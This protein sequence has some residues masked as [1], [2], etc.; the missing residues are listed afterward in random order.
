MKASS[1]KSFL[2]IFAAFS[3]GFMGCSE[4]DEPVSPIVGTWNFSEVAVDVRVNGMD[5]ATYFTSVL[6]WAQGDAA[7]TETFVK[8]LII[9]ELP[10]ENTSMEMKSDGFYNIRQNG[11]IISSGRYALENNDRILK[12]TSGPDTEEYEVQELNSNRLTLGFRISFNENQYGD[13]NIPELHEYDFVV[14][15]TK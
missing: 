7:M 2:L 5:L 9:E 11:N 15:F 14:K 12:L 13:D 6:G 10:Y 4:K 3:F 1:T 8:Q